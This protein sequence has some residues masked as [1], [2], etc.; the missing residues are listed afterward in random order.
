MS[1]HAG[2]RSHSRC[3]VWE[4]S[5]QR[6]RGWSSLLPHTWQGHIDTVPWLATGKRTLVHCA[7]SDELA[8]LLGLSVKHSTMNPLPLA[9]Y[10]SYTTCPPGSG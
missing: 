10:A 4:D 3:H 7:L 1:N 8:H 9:E 2:V 5:C 6:L